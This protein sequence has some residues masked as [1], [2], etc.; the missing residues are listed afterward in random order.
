MTE[1][2][3]AIWRLL[4]SRQ[5]AG[6]KF[7][8]QQPMRRYI[9]DFVCLSHKLVVEVDGGQHADATA[10]DQRR[11]QFFLDEGFQILRFWNNEV[12]EN[13]D[14]V[15]ARIVEV[16]DSRTPHPP[17]ALRRAPPSPT[18]GAGI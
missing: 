9:V 1:A 15:C 3:K 14:G 10:Y 6:F 4:R 18:R 16:L 13:R 7:R 11:T 8:R 12:L 17:G 2:E 5:L